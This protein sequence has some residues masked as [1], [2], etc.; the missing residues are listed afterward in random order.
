[1][2]EQSEANNPVI[3]C[4]ECLQVDGTC[5]MVCWNI[6]QLSLI[7]IT[8]VCACEFRR[9][10]ES[11]SSPTLGLTRRS[12]IRRSD[13]LATVHVGTRRNWM[14]MRMRTS[15]CFSREVF[16][17]FTSQARSIWVHGTGTQVVED[18][19]FVISHNNRCIG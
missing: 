3:L 12:W 9:P 18:C 5:I 13:R 17:L 7:R 16:S 10:Y 11:T 4:N 2:G 14:R 8:I 15:R 6:L 19:F 1:M